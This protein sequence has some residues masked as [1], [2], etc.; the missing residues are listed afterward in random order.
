ML[1]K[2]FTDV[3]FSFQFVLQW[4]NH[5]ADITNS[6]SAMDLKISPRTVS[7]LRLRWKFYAGRDISATP[8]L[9]DGTVY[10]P[11]W[12]GFLYA[13]NAFTG[14]LQW[15]QN[16]SELTGLQGTGVT[17]NVTVSR[18]TPTVTGNL[19]IVSIYGPAVVIAVTRS[20]GTLVWLTTI[21]S[22]PRAVITMSG[23]AYLG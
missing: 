22:R 5:G 15:K 12:N 17:V 9:A 13:V 6:R 1:E 10:F 16:L 21:D 19:L 8:A 23:T 14:E 3:F 4:L 20:S 2:H 7:N 18:A 11:S